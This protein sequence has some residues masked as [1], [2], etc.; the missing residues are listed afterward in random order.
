MNI[1]GYGDLERVLVVTLPAD[2]FFINLSEQTIIVAL[3]TPW[4][5]R[6]RMHQRRTIGVRNLHAVVGLVK[7][8]RKWGVID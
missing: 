4:I 5:L 3:I 6:I 8:Q 1:L 7:T 2:P